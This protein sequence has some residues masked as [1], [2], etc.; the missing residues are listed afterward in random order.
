MKC[1]ERLVKPHLTTACLPASFDLLQFAYRPNHSTEDTIS[2]TLHSVLT[3][4]DHKDTYT[5]ILYIDFSSAFNTIIPL[6]LMEKLVLIGLGN[7]TCLWIID[8]LPGRPQSVRVGKNTS[9][10]IT[11]S[12]GSPQG[13]VLSPLLF[14]L[15]IHH[16]AARY[17]G[18]ITKFADDTTVVG[19]IRGNEKINVQGR[20]QNLEGW[21]HENNL[22]LSVD[23][24]KEMII[25]FWRS[26]PE[27]I[28]LIISGRT[29]ERVENHQVPRSADLAG[30]GLEQEHFSDHKT[31]PAEYALSEEAETR[32][33]PHQNPQDF[34]QRCG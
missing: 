5:K 8:F 6:R 11:L 7:A 18:N 14:M 23:K 20:S 25:N 17:E 3:H 9:N 27:H 28:P 1:Y 13:C 15:L 29:V 4:L 31:S 10:F 2:T 34:L 32:V 30:P 16:C 26:R 12:T 24:M 19:L 22:L 21:C 33:S